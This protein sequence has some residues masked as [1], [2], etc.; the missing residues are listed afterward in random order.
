MDLG[1][2]RCCRQPEIERENFWMTRALGPRLKESNI[3]PFY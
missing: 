3:P 2:G 1:T